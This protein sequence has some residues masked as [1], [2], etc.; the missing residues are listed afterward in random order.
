MSPEGIVLTAKHVMPAGSHCAGEIGR[1]SPSPSF[2]LTPDPHQWANWD[3]I[4]LRLAK[5]Q[6]RVFPFVRYHK[7]TTELKGKPILARGIKDEGTEIAVSPGWI[8]TVDIDSRG[9]IGTNAL[10]SSGMSGGPVVLSDDGSLIGIVAGADFD[11]KTGAPAS[12]GVLAVQLVAPDL[13]LAEAA[14]VGLLGTSDGHCKPAA[15]QGYY[16]AFQLGM[17]TKLY[18]VADQLASLSHTG[19][20]PSTVDLKKRVDSLNLDVD[21]ETMTSG[22]GKASTANVEAKLRD[23]LQINYP[24]DVIN[25]FDVGVRIGAA[26]GSS[27]S[28]PAIRK[29]D[30]NKIVKAAREQWNDD[31]DFINNATS[32][33]GVPKLELS[34]PP[35]AK[36][37]PSSAACAAADTLNEYL[38]HKASG[39]PDAIRRYQDAIGGSA[40]AAATP[41]IHPGDRINGKRLLYFTKA[42]DLGVVQSTLAA[43]NLY[44]EE[45][46]GT[47][48]QA[49]NVISCQPDDDIARIKWLARTLLVAGVHLQGI[50]PQKRKTN[51]IGVEYYPQY[52][53][54]PVLNEYSLGNIK[55]CP[56][57]EDDQ[58][59][60][61]YVSVVN[62]CPQ[63]I[64]GTMTYEDPFANSW[65]SQF[66]T[67]N[68]YTRWFLRN[69]NGLYPTSQL[70]FV[71]FLDLSGNQTTWRIGQTICE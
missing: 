33:L 8:S 11:K 62:K 57:W 30:L 48:D 38:V 22:S 1:P 25:M 32:H 20:H 16:D 60:S 24:V 46:S 7:I 34:L 19:V 37:D 41:P 49:T 70:S 63:Q 10:S 15:C 61:R 53:R 13:D 29:S 66:V 64:V 27:L 5:E 54:M 28:T 55:D 12:Y 42:A 52:A 45:Q 6:G 14:S 67:I 26:A 59:P 44:Y 65:I 9:M 69:Q 31:L 4:A 18:R 58:L 21:V 36:G 39:C 43:N 47:N 3:V 35:G 23:K 56:V 51:L 50:A 68:G 2:L 40:V 17:E 71:H